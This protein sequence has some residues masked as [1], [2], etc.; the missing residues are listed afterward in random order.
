[1]QDAEMLGLRRDGRVEAR[2]AL[3]ACLTAEYQAERA[4]A[5]A[6]AAIWRAREAALSDSEDDTAVEEFASW[7][8]RGKRDLAT[9]Q[10]AL[11]R[12]H[13]ETLRARAALAHADG[14]VAVGER[15]SGLSRG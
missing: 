13:A 1:M 7:L 9:A 4:L 3:N 2:E 15:L 10:T 6:E 5:A 11:D 8:P 12:A 14:V